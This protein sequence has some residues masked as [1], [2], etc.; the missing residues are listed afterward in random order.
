MRK[1]AVVAA[2][3]AL[4]TVAVLGGA[5]IYTAQPDEGDA[6]AQLGEH[7]N[8]TTLE[9]LEVLDAGAVLAL[10]GIQ[11]EAGEVVFLVRRYVP[12]DRGPALRPA[13]FV[14]SA[15]HYQQT[16]TEPLHG[17]KWV[18]PNKRA[19]RLVLTPADVGAAR[20]HPLRC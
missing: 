4:L 16:P 15:D 7:A 1:L 11:I 17:G 20:G 12:P 3:L 19:T 2:G 5:A 8:L 13:L 9:V 10:D 18:K 6:I 14:P